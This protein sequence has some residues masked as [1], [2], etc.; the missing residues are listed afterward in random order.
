MAH[1]DCADC[2]A[3][4][5][6][7][8]GTCRE[9]TPTEVF[10]AQEELRQAAQK[11]EVEW[12]KSVSCLGFTQQ[13]EKIKKEQDQAREAFLEPMLKD[14]RKKAKDLYNKHHPRNRGNS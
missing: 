3:S 10:D 6:I 13:I 9:C 7:G 11:A 5:G 8:Y 4:M 12:E 2:G 14:I 1:Y